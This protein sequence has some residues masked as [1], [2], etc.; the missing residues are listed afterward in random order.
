MS[1]TKK[2]CMLKKIFSNSFKASN[3]SRYGFLDFSI[4]P[5]DNKIIKDFCQI[6]QNSNSNNLETTGSNQVKFE[7]LTESYSLYIIPKNQHDTLSSF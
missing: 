1:I 6:F 7:L 3:F 2:L 5:T 4:I